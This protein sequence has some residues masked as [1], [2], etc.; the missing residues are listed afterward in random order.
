MSLVLEFTVSGTLDRER[1]QSPRKY[2]IALI[3]W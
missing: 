3:I 2:K 1:A